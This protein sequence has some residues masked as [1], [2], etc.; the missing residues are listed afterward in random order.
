MAQA[1]YESLQSTLRYRL[2]AVNGL[3]PTAGARVIQMSLQ[4][5]F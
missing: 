3:R 2:I 5:S 1:T 4:V